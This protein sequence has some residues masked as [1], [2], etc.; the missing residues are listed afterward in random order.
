MG[1]ARMS[2][3]LLAV[4]LDSPALWHAFVVHDLDYATALTRYLIAV[5]VAGLMLSLMRWLA[6]EYRRSND[7]PKPEAGPVGRGQRAGDRDDA[8][9]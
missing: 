4:V 9:G 2:T 8:D 1:F 5:V 7:S 6:S 3:L